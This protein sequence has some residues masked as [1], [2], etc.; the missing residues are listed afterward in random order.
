MDARIPVDPCI[1]EYLCIAEYMRIAGDT[2]ISVDLCV[3]MNPCIIKDTRSMSNNCVFT[4]IGC[5]CNIGGMFD[6]AT[7]IRMRFECHV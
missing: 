3:V 2:C 4:D 1:A 6:K 7:T 5:L